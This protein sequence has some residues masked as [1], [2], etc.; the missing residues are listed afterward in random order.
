MKRSPL[1]AGDALHLAVASLGGHAL[2]TLDARMKEGAVAV[3]VR[4]VG[5]KD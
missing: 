4:V 1:R 2:A 5:V 3:G